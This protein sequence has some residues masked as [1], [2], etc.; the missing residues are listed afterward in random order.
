M[1][2]DL[3]TAERYIADGREL[4]RRLVDG[5]WTIAGMPPDDA[6][7]QL[8]Q[9]AAWFEAPGRIPDVKKLE[10]GCQI[11]VLTLA[12][13]EWVILRLWALESV[14]K[15]KLKTMKAMDADPR[16]LPL[17][18]LKPPWAAIMRRRHVKRSE[19][20]TLVNDT[21]RVAL[22]MLKSR[23]PKPPTSVAKLDP[24]AVQEIVKIY[25]EMRAT[26]NQ[27]NLPSSKQPDHENSRF[28]IDPAMGEDLRFAVRFWGLVKD[29]TLLGP[30]VR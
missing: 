21:L 11:I 7:Q 12:V 27:S 15:M 13:L 17:D 5:S 24:T 20:N 25:R 29:T 14:P 19:S 22:P 23:W 9:L 2:W 18:A 6:V 4:D 8:E 30:M 3:R 10:L 28:E 26:I 1:N 16:W